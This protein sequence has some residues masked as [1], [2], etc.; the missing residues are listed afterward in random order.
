MLRFINLKQQEEKTQKSAEAGCYKLLSLLNFF[1]SVV[2]FQS[3]IVFTIVLLQ[4]IQTF[5]ENV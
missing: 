1:Y 4:T 3:L 2:H 5:R